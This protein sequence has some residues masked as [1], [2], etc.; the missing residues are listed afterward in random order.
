M[1]DDFRFLYGE[2]TVH[3]RRLLEKLVGSDEW[4]EFT[5]EQKVWPLMD[6][7][8]NVD[9]LVTEDWTGVSLR[10]FDVARQVWLIYWATSRDGVLQEPP[11]EGRFDGDVGSFYSDEELEGTP[12]RVRY[13][14]TKTDPEAPRWEQAFS[15]D[16]G[17]TWETNWIM[18]F[19]RRVA[20]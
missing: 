1:N 8:G 3:N 20:G 11:L 15:T 6:G 4:T 18:D 13:R 12:I 16:G 10:L 17:E 7:L 19:T 5:G 14:W 2:W 9:E